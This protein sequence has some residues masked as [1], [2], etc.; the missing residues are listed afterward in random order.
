MSSDSFK[1]FVAGNYK[2]VLANIIVL[3]IMYSDDDEIIFQ[4]DNHSSDTFAE[5]MK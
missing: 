2:T 5:V 3:M 1:C 4:Q